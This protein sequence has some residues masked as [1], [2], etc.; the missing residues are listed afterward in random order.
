MYRLSN[1][2]ILNSSVFI[3]SG[4]IHQSCFAYYTGGFDSSILIWL[5]ILPMLAGV[6]SGRIGVI[7]WSII[8]TLVVF[9]FF[10]LEIHGHPFPNLISPRGHIIAQSMIAFGWIFLSTI[11]IWVYVLLDEIHT[12]DLENK[13]QSIQ[14]L[15]FIL[16]HDISN[17]LNIV[18]GRTQLALSKIKIG[19]N[20][21]NIVLPLT[22]KS[23][24]EKIDKAARAIHSIVDN[25]KD[26]YSTEL[27]KK[28]IPLES[29]EVNQV[30]Q[31][32]KEN[33]NEKL[34]YKKIELR[35]YTPTEEVFLNSNRGLLIHQILCLGFLMMIGFSLIVEGFGFHIPKGYLYAAIGFSVIVE[36]I[37]QTMRRNQEKMVTTTDLRY[38]TASAVLRMLGGK[39]SDHA[40]EPEDVLATRAYADEVFDPEN[41]VYHSVLVQGVLGLSERP[42]KS[43]MTPR[44]ELEWIDLEDEEASIKSQLLSITHSRLI[45]AR[46]EL[47]NIAGVVLTHKVLNEY[48]ETGVLDFDKHLR[49]PVIVHENAQVLMVME[50]LRQAP[51]QMALVLNE[52][53]SIEGIATPIDVLEAIAGEFPDED[54]EDNVAESLEDGS[55]MLDGS[56]DIRHVSL[57]LD[58]DLVD[59]SDQYSTLSGYILFHLGRLPENGSSLEADGCIFE[60]VT[61]D[62]HKIEK[63]HVIPKSDL[64]KESS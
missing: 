36:F 11:V 45:V 53:G 47:D 27:G 12:H 30:F 2:H 44:P 26:L 18:M 43:V 42:V 21:E 24:I 14:N 39:S 23:N 50:Q 10:W 62:G 33:F 20:E 15:V 58:R 64:H 28:E 41:G 8:T 35:S 63:V 19:T 52:Y 49:E 3:A 37:N 59:E 25:V 57:L 6:I 9:V 61:M 55:L 32:V 29:I 34:T 31:E 46:G 1:N 54:A 13:N 48:I 4:I 17:H 51:L 56:T 22:E 16:A 5:G 60:V 38:K 40:S 7:L